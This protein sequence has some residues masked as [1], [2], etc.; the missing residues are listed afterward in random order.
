[1]GSTNK[2]SHRCS[3]C[4]SNSIS[5][6][7]PNG[8]SYCISNSISD[9]PPN[10]QSYCISNSIS[11][12]LSNGQSYSV[13]NSFSNNSFAHNISLIGTNYDFCGSFI[14]TYRKGFQRSISII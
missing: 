1:M 9:C 3:Y 11:D 7:L 14:A 5:D 10:G 8:Q 4:I 6:C 12:C 13:A 2:Q